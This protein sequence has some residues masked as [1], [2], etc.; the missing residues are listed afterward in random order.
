MLFFAPTDLGV[1]I[2]LSIND[3]FWRNDIT[4][5]TSYAG[6]PGDHVEALELIRLGRLHVGEMITHRFGLGETGE[7]FK[8]VA[9]AR[10]SLKVIIE[11][12]R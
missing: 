9:E 3:L 6:S 1:T 8:L 5:T 7:G 10:D 2:P 11:P 4:L 12:Q